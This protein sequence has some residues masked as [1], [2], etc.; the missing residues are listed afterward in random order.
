MF[1][2]AIA[3]VLFPTLSRFAARADIDG[4]RNTVSLGLRQIVF[5]LV[6]A[7]VASA[8]LAEPIVRLLYQRGEFG[9]DQTPVVAGALAAFSLGL[10]FNG[11]MLMLNRGFFSLQAPW[12]P[13]W[14]ALA[15]L[16]LNVALYAVFYRVGTWGIPFAISLSNVAGAV[17]LVALLRRK[18]GGLSLRPTIRTLILVSI[19]SAVLAAVSYGVWWALDDAFGR[20]TLAQV[21][22]LGGGLAAGGA[23]YLISCRL[24]GVHEL[25][26]LLSLRTRLRRA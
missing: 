26:A 15:S 20:S 22:S 10:V 8:V 23:A 6:P 9:P 25:G 14:A 7:G 24:L 18:I 3:T 16:V 17:L 21:A 2:V 1:S 19:A 13:T 4:F 5:L 11:M 12:T